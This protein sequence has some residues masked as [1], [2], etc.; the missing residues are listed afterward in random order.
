MFGAFLLLIISNLLLGLMTIYKT[1]V[2]LLTGL[3][4]QQAHYGPHLE[5]RSGHHLHRIS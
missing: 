3:G 1:N 5:P 4:P 2:I